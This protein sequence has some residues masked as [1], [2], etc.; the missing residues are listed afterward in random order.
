MHEPIKFDVSGLQ[1]AL[2][3]GGLPASVA[4]LN[5]KVP[6]R[7]TGL[8]LAEGGSLRN[9]ALFDKQDSNAPL[10][11]PLPVSDS[12]C[13]VIVESGLP[14]LINHASTD[15]RLAVREHPAAAKFESYCGVPL[16]DAEGN[17]LGSLCHFDVEP[18]EGS[19][20]DLEQMLQL[21]RAFL[22]HLQK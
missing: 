4:Y 2:S 14:L 16:I 10:W 15:R 12:F 17:V 19:E 22:P 13:S 20:A 3:E 5:A 8:F 11:E 9:V 21:P 6:Y 18:R 1:A 7:F